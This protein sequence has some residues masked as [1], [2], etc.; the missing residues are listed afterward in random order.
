MVEPLS[1]PMEGSQE[2]AAGLILAAAVSK[3]QL[4]P[5]KIQT[6]QMPKGVAA[7]RG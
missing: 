3:S 6:G 7:L 2:P 4:C 5:P 1:L